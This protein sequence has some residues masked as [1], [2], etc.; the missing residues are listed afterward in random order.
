[1]GQGLERALYEANR[2]WPCQSPLL[3]G[4]HVAEPEALLP[5]LERVA[6][7]GKT[8]REP[9]DAH[10]A[11]FCAARMK[12]FPERILKELDSPE[13]LVTFRLGV[14]HLLVELQRLNPRLRVPALSRWMAGLLKPVFESFHN[15]AY[16]ERLA[17]EVELASGRGDL[18]HLQF[19][20]DDLDSRT[21]DEQGF[22]TA[23]REHAETSRVLAW[24]EAGGMSSPAFVRAKSN[25]VG[26]VLAAAISGLM[27]V[28]MTLMYLS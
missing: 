14:L 12:P 3:A 23:R 28:V 19:L 20:V 1:M 15:R 6:R 24:L 11:A 13:Q 22:E 25:Q 17:R 9:V 27:M 18:E 4:D 5:A 16:R 7:R 10:I 8:D 26:S 2:T 21:Q